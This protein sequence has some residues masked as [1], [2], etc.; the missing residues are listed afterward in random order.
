[1]SYPAVKFPRP[2]TPK[3]PIKQVLG[4]LTVQ[5]HHATQPEYWV[6][7]ALAYWDLEFI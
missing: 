4:Y 5:T 3:E 7:M 2:Q 1:M 6:A